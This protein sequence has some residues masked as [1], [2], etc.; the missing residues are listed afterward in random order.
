[1][2][3][4]FNKTAMFNTRLPFLAFLALYHVL[5]CSGALSVK[6][7]AGE[8]RCFIFRTPDVHS[9][10][11]GSFEIISDLTLPNDPVTGTLFD[12]E[13][14]V[15]WHSDQ[16]ADYGQFIT[17][18]LGRYHLC[19]GNGSGGYKDESDR[20]R[21]RMRVEGHHIDDD[22]FDYDNHDGN[23]RMIAFNVRVIPERENNDPSKNNPNKTAERTLHLAT[24][25]NDKFYMLLDH[26][27]YMKSRDHVQRDLMEST[28][29]MLMK[30][31][32]LE[33]IVLIL[34][35]TSQVIYFRKFFETKR[36]L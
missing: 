30:W 12:D 2:D 3:L 6:I 29:S 36:Y 34:I 22:N 33:A 23:E 19:F 26:Q 15:L 28:F 17:H 10:I 1:M 7:Q 32:V 13:Y 5:P 21:E 25:L 24:R 16:K 11:S 9:H 35:A 4:C 20:E 27:E 31:T 18:G 14:K 8:E